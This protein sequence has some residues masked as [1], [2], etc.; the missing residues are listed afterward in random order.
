M[1]R[2]VA[3]DGSAGEFLFGLTLGFLP[4]GFLYAALASAAASAD[5]LTGASAMVSFGLGTVPVL[6]VIG[7]GGHAAGR[8]WNRGIATVAPAVM[9]VNAV[10]LLALA[11]RGPA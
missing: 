1:T 9:A 2:R 11:W 7:V 8:R 10:L 3:R 4:C 5:P 6:A